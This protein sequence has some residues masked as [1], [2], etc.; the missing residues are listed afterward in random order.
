MVND[1]VCLVLTPLV[2]HI[3]KRLN[4]DPL[5]HLVGLATASNIGSVGTITGN[6]QNL[7]I[8]VSSRIPYM[9]FAAHL[10]P[11]ALW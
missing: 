2:I 10:M 7:I 5:P 4:F 6:P 9:T 11:V 8:G 3:A 1:I